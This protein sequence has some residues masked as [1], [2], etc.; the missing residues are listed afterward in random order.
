MIEKCLNNVT[1]RIKEKKSSKQQIVH[2]DRPKPFSNLRHCPMYLQEINQK[3]IQPTQDRVDIHLHID[4]TLNDDDCPNFLAAPSSIFTP[5][6][7][8]GRTTASSTTNGIIQITSS[9]PARGEIT[10]S[11]P[12]LSR[13]PTLQ[14]PRPHAGDDV[15]IQSP[16]TLQS[17]MQSL[18]PENA[19]LHERQSPRDNVTEVVD[20]AS[21]NLRRT[22]PANTSKMQ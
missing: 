16:T 21:R 5:I 20:A 17:D 2:Y 11:P 6:A 14:Q 4:G 15:A 19:S 1:F 10:R 8:E 9:A 7:A 13:L 12:V 18:I 3:K 22:P